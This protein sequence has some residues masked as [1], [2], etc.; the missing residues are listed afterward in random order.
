MNERV[1]KALK[2][3]NIEYREFE[4]AGVTKTV[5]D[6]AKT[7]NI[8]RGQVAKSILVK[9]SKK[10]NFA[11]I[12]A[13]G[14]KKIS[15]KKMRIYFNCKTSFANA[16]DTLNI[17]GF[18]FGGVC[19]FGIDKNIDVLID[20]SMKRFEDLYIACGSD[21]SLAKMSYE[22]IL[23]KISAEEVDLTEN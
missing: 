21:S 11:M 10:D 13:S 18:T 20:K 1:L 15:S 6:A 2:E 7:L 16:E 9:P 23:E 12:I 17:T 19:P 8:E 3:L 22:E 14:D 4:E 5:D